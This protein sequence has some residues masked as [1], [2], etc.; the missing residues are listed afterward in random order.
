MTGDEDYRIY[1]LNMNSQFSYGGKI[2]YDWGDGEKSFKIKDYI[3]Y[4]PK[5]QKFKIF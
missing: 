1:N 5:Q 3:N 4:I 2:T